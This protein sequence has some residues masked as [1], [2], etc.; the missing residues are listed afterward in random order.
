MPHDRWTAPPTYP[1]PFYGQPFDVHKEE[2]YKGPFWALL[3]LIISS[4]CRECSNYLPMWHASRRRSSQTSSS[5]SP[6]A[7]VESI[8]K[9]VRRVDKATRT[10]TKW[11]VC[12]EVMDEKLKKDR[13]EGVEK[14]LGI[15]AA[16]GFVGG[17]GYSYGSK[18]ASYSVY[19]RQERLTN[20]LLIRSPNDSGRYQRYRWYQR[21]HLQ[22]SGREDDANWDT[23]YENFYTVNKC[24]GDCPPNA[25]CEWG[26]CECDE[27]FRRA[28][29]ACHNMVGG[30]PTNLSPLSPECHL[31]AWATQASESNSCLF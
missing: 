6:F 25:H 1:P 13:E 24:L 7:S 30:S 18:L 20:W 12:P 26:V 14:S 28:W 4:N 21:H 15:G 10:A 16:P 3:E 31:H 29:G 19:H 5:D 8:I 2:R 11:E 9:E 27:G 17:S 23:K 22:A